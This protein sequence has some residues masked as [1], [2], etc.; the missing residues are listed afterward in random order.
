MKLIFISLLFLFTN[1]SFA[2]GRVVSYEEVNTSL[3]ASIENIETCGDWR[4]N[5]KLGNF[6]LLTLYYSGQNLL[7][8]DIVA[9]ND[10]ETQMIPI[11]GFTFKEVNNDH[12]DITIDNLVCHSLAI[13]KI[14]INATATNGHNNQVFKFSLIIDGEKNTYQY[15]E[16]FSNQ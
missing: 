15:K 3:F 10:S 9:L 8:V 14:Q 6:R 1:H 4:V 7:F 5:G 11:K 2:L 16:D 12:A 13:N